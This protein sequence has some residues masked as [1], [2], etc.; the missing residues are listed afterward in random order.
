MANA[1]SKKNSRFSY[2]SGIIAELRK[3]VWLTRQE[4]TYLTALV[5]SVAITVGAILGSIDF[6]LSQLVDKLFLGG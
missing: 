4:A 2:I 6:G 1:V 3:V 5:L